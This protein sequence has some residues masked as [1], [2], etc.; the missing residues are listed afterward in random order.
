MRLAALL[1]PSVPSSWLFER[2]RPACASNPR[3]QP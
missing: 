3:R 2:L 1:F